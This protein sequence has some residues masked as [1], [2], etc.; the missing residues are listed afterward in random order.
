MHTPKWFRIAHA[1]HHDSRPPTAW[2]A[3]SFHPVEAVTGAVIIPLLVFMVPVHS[4]VLAA[5]LFVMTFM[6]RP[7]TIWGGRFSRA[8]WFRAR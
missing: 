8:S 6:G 4:A 3:M 2:A 7:P 1:V 5:I